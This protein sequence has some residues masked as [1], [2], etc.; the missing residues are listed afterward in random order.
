MS[1]FVQ[2]KA[3]SG[4]NGSYAIEA[5]GPSWSKFNISQSGE[6]TSRNSLYEGNSHSFIASFKADDGE[7]FY[8]TVNLDITESLQATSIVIADE[9]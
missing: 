7:I 8:E 4:I 5:T 2:K 3:R 9:A 1:A 6:I